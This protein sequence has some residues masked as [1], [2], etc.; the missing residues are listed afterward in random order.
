MSDP[1]KRYIVRPITGVGDYLKLLASGPFWFSVLLKYL[2]GTFFA[3]WGL[4]T[5][6]TANSVRSQ[7]IGATVS[8]LGFM[9]AISVIL[10][11]LMLCIHN[12]Q[13]RERRSE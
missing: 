13:L 2:I 7:I 8:V 12:A 5:L 9:L 11:Y 6:F 10:V 4:V 3:V 1:K